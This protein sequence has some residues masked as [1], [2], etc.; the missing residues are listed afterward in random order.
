LSAD[1]KATFSADV[2][3]TSSAATLSLAT[4]SRERDA[5]SFSDSR[6]SH[7]FFT[8]HSAPALLMIRFNFASPL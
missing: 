5:A 8:N 3:A 1:G 7:L 4:N 2:K 6:L